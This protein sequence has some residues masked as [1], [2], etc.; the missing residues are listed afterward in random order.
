MRDYNEEMI[1]I[2]NQKVKC[3]NEIKHISLYQ[4]TE[5][6]HINRIVLYMG[7]NIEN[8]PIMMFM[9]TLSIVFQTTIG[10]YQCK[11]VSPK[12]RFETLTGEGLKKFLTTPI[13][14]KWW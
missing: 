1:K 3:I 14:H 4:I 13:V 6:E 8:Q 9:D 10:N 2:W 5:G 7:C 11:W 12:P